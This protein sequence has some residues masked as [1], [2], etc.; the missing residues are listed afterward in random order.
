MQYHKLWKKDIGRELSLGM[1]FRTLFINLRDE[2][3][4][5]YLEKFNHT[6]ILNTINSY[7]DIDYPSKLAVPLLKAS[8]SLIKLLPT[9]IKSRKS[10]I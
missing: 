8:P 4:D 1:R 9:A 5:H 2:Q 10:I 3:I 7:G 6:K